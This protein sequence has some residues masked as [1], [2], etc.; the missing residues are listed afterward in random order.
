MNLRRSVNMVISFCKLSFLCE[1]SWFFSFKSGH[2]SH[3][4]LYQIHVTLILFEISN[5]YSLY[6][7]DGLSGCMDPL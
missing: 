3:V 2:A 6:G 5:K 4:F 1:S 7:V